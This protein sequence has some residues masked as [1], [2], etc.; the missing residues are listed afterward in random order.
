MVNRQ[1]KIKSDGGSQQGDFWSCL[2]PRPTQSESEPPAEHRPPSPTST[3]T[4]RAQGQASDPRRGEHGDPGEPRGGLPGA[5]TELPT[6]T[7]GGR[8]LTRLRR[9]PAVSSA[10]GDLRRNGDHRELA[11]ELR[12]KRAEVDRAAR[13]QHQP[14]PLGKVQ[15]T[16]DRLFLAGSELARMGVWERRVRRGLRSLPPGV[17]EA[18]QSSWAAMSVAAERLSLET[19]SVRARAWQLRD[20][21]RAVHPSHRTAECGWA[22]IGEVGITVR[23]GGGYTLSSVAHCG[24]VHDCPVCAL[25]IKSKRAEQ[26]KRGVELHRLHFG[27]NS[28][29]LNTFTIRHAAGQSLSFIAERFQLA[30]NMFQTRVPTLTKIARSQARARGQRG[31]ATP[32]ESI[33][34]IGGVYGAEVTHGRNGWHYHRHQIL[35]SERNLEP[36]ELEQ[37]SKECSSW[38]RECVVQCMGPEFEPS[39]ERGFDCRPLNVADYIAKLGLELSDVGTK[40]ASNGN[41]TQWGLLALASSGDQQAADLLYE[42]S[43]AMRGKKAIQFSERLLARWKALGLEVTD[44]DAALADES[45]GQR[46]VCELG[47]RAW[48]QLRRSGRACHVLEAETDEELAQRL[49]SVLELEHVEGW[50]DGA[51]VERMAELAQDAAERHAMRLEA[52]GTRPTKESRRASLGVTR[53]RYWSEVDS[54]NRK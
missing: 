14:A 35:A 22:R 44:D 8:A 45:V 10:P 2:P 12:R 28:L 6:A 49:A 11:L 31:P 33:E 53:R 32:L 36:E 43:L 5:S 39:E 7:D 20:R 24:S 29:V 18:Q 21:A 3:T 50:G 13:W 23:Q 47:A 51:R 1:G 17:Q 42:Y 40:Q 9:R 41:E 48:T 19:P 30:W 4:H 37:F 27:P 52:G 38:W 54:S 26:I 16:P 46:L 34:A 15:D 25:A